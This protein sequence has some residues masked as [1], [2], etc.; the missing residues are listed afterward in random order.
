MA[1]RRRSTLKRALIPD[2]ANG[3]LERVRWGRER[4]AGLQREV[5]RAESD[6][7][8]IAVDVFNEESAPIDGVTVEHGGVELGV[9]TTR[10]S[11]PMCLWSP[12]TVCVYAKR[13]DEAMSIPGQR[14]WRAWREAHTGQPDE[15]AVPDEPSMRTDACLFCGVPSGRD[16]SLT[17][18][19]RRSR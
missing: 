14:A 17:G 15:R 10:G 3:L 11:G 12:I 18:P 13:S 16:G 7:L 8:K 6:L 2:R 5:G 9:V 1:D 19:A 4:L